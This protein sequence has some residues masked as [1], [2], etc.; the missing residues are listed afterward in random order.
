LRTFAAVARL[1]GMGRAAEV[2][3]TVQS[4][5]TA[6][7]RRLEEGLGTP[8]FTRHARGVALTAAGERLLPYALRVARLLEEA[9][10]AVLDDGT[11]QGP[12]VVGALET[13]AALRLAPRLAG[14]AAAHPAVDLTLRTGTT[15][16]L[17]EQVLEGALQGAFVCGPVAHPELL[18]EPVFAEELALLAAPGVDPFAGDAALRIVV[19]RRGCSYRQRLEEV[20]ARR[21][22]PAPR[23]MEFATLEAIFGC[24]AAGLGITLLPAALVGSVWEGRVALHALPPRDGQVETVFIRRRDVEAGS[25]LRAFLEAVRPAA[26]L[27][28]AAE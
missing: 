1:G 21:G 19:L 24:V 18:A 15:C 12:L 11:P 28:A 9:R 6:R 23:V 14:F 25:A 17:T 13:T 8:L 16:E 2:L 7:I 5:V 22:V 4:S 20:L 26:R 3:N 10:R 27:Q